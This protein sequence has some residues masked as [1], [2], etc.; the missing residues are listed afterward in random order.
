LHSSSATGTALAETVG[1]QTSPG[2]TEPAF[3]SPTGE[4]ARSKSGRTLGFVGLG[5]LVLAGVSVLLYRALGTTAPTGPEA[6]PASPAALVPAAPPAQEK[7]AATMPEVTPVVA[8]PSASATP[9]PDTGNTGSADAGTAVDGGAP[10]SAG[11]AP[12]PRRP[13]SSAPKGDQPK[14]D[15]FDPNS[16]GDRH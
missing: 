15:A 10:S 8:A 13:T 16:F 12:T 3:V 14:V 5:L 2:R 11:R 9:A 4:A 1:I 7:P 6:N